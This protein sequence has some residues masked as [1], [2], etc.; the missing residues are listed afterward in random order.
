MRRGKLMLFTLW[1]LI[2]TTEMVAQER[3]TLPLLSRSLEHAVVD[4][5]MLRFYH[6]NVALHLPSHSP[7]DR[8]SVV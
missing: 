3:D 8:K 1:L 2:A 6:D 4:A 7:L 5:T